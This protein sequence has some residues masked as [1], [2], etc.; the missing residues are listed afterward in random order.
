MISQYVEDNPDQRFGQVLRNLGVV[1]DVGVKDS[2][3]EE[4]ET[5]DYYWF[6]GI[7]EEPINTLIRMKKALNGEFVNTKIVTKNKGEKL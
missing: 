5:P 1:V 6:R 2:A 4:W 7:H 3:D